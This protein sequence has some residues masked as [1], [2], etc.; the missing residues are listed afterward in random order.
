MFDLNLKK[1]KKTS[2]PTQPLEI[3]D[4]GG[5]CGRKMFYKNWNN[6]R[7]RLRHHHFIPG[8]VIRVGHMAAT[9]LGQKYSGQ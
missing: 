1:K 7:N 3:A 6:L 2:M 4:I 9:F 8:P 5:K